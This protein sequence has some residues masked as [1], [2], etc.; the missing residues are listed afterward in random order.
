MLSSTFSS[1]IGSGGFL[2]INPCPV[3]AKQRMATQV[4]LATPYR[5]RFASVGHFARNRSNAIPT[6]NNSNTSHTRLENKFCKSQSIAHTSTSRMI[7]E[8]SKYIRMTMRPTRKCYS[9]YL[10]QMHN[11]KYL[12]RAHQLSPNRVISP[13]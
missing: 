8:S 4:A 13:Y 5:I 11:Q 7:S 6:P 9:L 3:N 2:Y 10:R 12:S 1:L